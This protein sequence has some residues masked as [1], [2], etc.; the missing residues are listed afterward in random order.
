MAVLECRDGCG[1]TDGEAS[2]SL[3][4][5]SSHLQ[6][7]AVPFPHNHCSSCMVREEMWHASGCN[8]R[9]PIVVARRNL[10]HL[11]NRY[12]IS[13][14]SSECGDDLAVMTSVKNDSLAV[15]NDLFQACQATF[16]Q[17]PKHANTS[18]PS[19]LL[20]DFP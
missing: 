12:E 11:A 1:A 5:G 7:N 9:Q 14:P 17:C 16:H 13:D 3:N 4:L 15:F 2:R 6:V 19:L 18:Y 8:R 20:F 10:K